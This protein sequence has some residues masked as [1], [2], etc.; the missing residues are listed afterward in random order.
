MSYKYV[1]FGG[2]IQG[3]AR[4]IIH[5]DDIKT[6]D[7]VEEW[8]WEDPVIKKEYSGHRKLEGFKE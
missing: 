1:E 8:K 3:N 7:L 5:D 6:E 2:E 4:E